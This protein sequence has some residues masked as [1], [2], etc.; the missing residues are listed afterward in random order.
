MRR[1]NKAPEDVVFSLG[2]LKG[3]LEEKLVREKAI[4]LGGAGRAPSP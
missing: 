4:E 1:K 2:A 3:L